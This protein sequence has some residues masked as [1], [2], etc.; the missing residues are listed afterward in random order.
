MK[1]LSALDSLT[2]DEVCGAPFP[3]W[4]DLLI[5]QLED[6]LQQLEQNCEL[7]EKL[8]SGERR[9]KLEQ[10]AE[11]FC[12]KNKDRF[13]FHRKQLRQMEKAKSTASREPEDGAQTEFES[14]LHRTAGLT[15]RSAETSEGGV[16]LTDD[17]GVSQKLANMKLLGD[18]G[19]DKKKK[20]R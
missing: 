13:D 5:D 15:E 8:F 2:G 9:Q 7:Y 10:T 11:Y 16:G 4:F 12:E 17:S 20:R 18:S 19:E 14:F 1:S 3:R 6:A